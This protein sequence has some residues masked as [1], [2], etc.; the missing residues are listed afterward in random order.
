MD[1][2]D[3]ELLNNEYKDKSPFEIIKYIYDKI[4]ASRVVLASSLSIEDQLLTDILLKIDSK[5]RIFFIDTGRH[6]QSTYDLMERTMRRYHFNYEVYTPES[7]DLEPLIR[8]YGPN[9]FYQSVDLRKKCCEIRKVKP[10]KR[11]LA[12]VDGWIC[13]LRREQSVTRENINIFEWDYVHS[14]YKINPIAFWTE[15]MVWEYIK[16]ENIPYNSLY[17]KG[18]RSIGCQPCTRA[19]KPGEDVRS[20]RWWWED[21]DKKECGLHIQNKI[22][23]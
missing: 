15:D 8:K 3:L 4:G 18:F 20:G 9:L 22:A 1:K 6:F 16:K 13:G 19:V 10:L 7:Q 2:L 14:I 12:T 23:E 17:D 11:V 5:A 21:P